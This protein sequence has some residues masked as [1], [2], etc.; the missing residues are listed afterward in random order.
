MKNNIIIRKIDLNDNQELASIVRTALAEF[1]ADKPGTVYYDNTT[2][3]L[4]ELFQQPGSLYYVAQR[5]EKLLGGAGIFPS[6]G[7]P[8]KTCELVKMYLRAEA[9][10]Q[11]LGKLLI[12]KCLEFARMYGYEQVYIET[13]P[14]LSKA[15]SIYEKF[16]FKYLKGPIGNTGHFGCDVW[17]L[18]KL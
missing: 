17:M 18:K 15:V 14:E 16:G 2:D 1:G 9:R 6:D 8:V 13:M 12:E 11:G 5:G 4:Y 7:L 10:G 3:H